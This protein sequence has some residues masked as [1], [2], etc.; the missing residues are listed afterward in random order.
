MEVQHRYTTS[1][2]PGP[3][4]PGLT[5]GRCGPGQEAKF[6]RRVGLVAASYKTP[7]PDQKRK[8]AVS[9]GAS[10]ILTRRSTNRYFAALPAGAMKNGLDFVPPP[11]MQMPTEPTPYAGT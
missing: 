11:R 5:L 4:P 2:P 3:T 1:L 9:C 6:R 10:P 8:R 7:S